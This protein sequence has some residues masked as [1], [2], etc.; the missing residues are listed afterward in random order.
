M[1]ADWEQRT[2]VTVAPASAALYLLAPPDQLLTH[3]KRK[4]D[5]VQRGHGHSRQS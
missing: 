4:P 2:K 3:R 5:I 1:Y